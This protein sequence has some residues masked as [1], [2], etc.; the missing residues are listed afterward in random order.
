VT[1]STPAS[2]ACLPKV[3]RSVWGETFHT[4]SEDG[5]SPALQVKDAVAGEERGCDHSTTHGRWALSRKVP[6]TP[7]VLIERGAFLKHSHFCD[8]ASV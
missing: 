4:P 1:K 7:R 3:W 5:G 8:V 2:R 6:E